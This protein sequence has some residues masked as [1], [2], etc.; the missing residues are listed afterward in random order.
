[1]HDYTE[2]PAFPDF[3]DT[4]WAFGYTAALSRAVTQG[5]LNGLQ[6]PEVV[7]TRDRMIVYLAQAF[8]VRS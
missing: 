1:M 7:L 6:G 2:D 8:G 4:F 5:H 3:R